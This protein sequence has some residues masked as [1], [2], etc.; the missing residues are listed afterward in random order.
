MQT[1]SK[2]LLILHRYCVRPNSG[3]IEPKKDVEVQVLL[4]AMKEDPPADAKCRDKFLVQSI[5]ISADNE[6]SNIQQVVCVEV[7]SST[8]GARMLTRLISGSTSKRPPSHR[9]KRRRSEFYSSLRRAPPPA[10]TA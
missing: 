4:Q 9:S 5:A 8:A 2:P 1:N 6:Y 10:S 7:G 3:R